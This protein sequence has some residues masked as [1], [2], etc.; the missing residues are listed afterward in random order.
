MQRLYCLIYE[1]YRA[2]LA[3]TN[4]HTEWMVWV[5]HVDER[6]GG[7]QKLYFSVFSLIS[8]SFIMKAAPSNVFHWCN[9]R[10]WLF[11]VS[12]MRPLSFSGKWYFS[13]PMDLLIIVNHFQRVRVSFGTSRKSE[14]FANAAIYFKFMLYASC[15]GTHKTSQ[16]T[17]N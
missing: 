15:H 17:K 13:L 1:R 8:H 11:F 6:V 12:V 3:H 5:M 16:K 10:A 9:T 2:A 4:T 14:T 7:A